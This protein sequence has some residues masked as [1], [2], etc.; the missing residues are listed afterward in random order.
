MQKRLSDRVT[1]YIL[2]MIM[3]EKRFMPEEKT[4]NEIE[5]SREWE[6]SRTTLREVVRILVAQ[7]KIHRGI[8]T[9]VREDF[10]IGEK[11]VLSLTAVKTN[12]RDLYDMRLIVEPEAAYY[13]AV[14]DGDEE[15]EHIL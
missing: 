9:F 10:K 13:A 6:I 8:G 15:F 12:I 11:S 7:G 1:D 2:T 14:R 4:P 5:L 3:I